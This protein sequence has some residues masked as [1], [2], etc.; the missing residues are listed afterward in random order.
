MSLLAMTVVACLVAAGCGDDGDADAESGGETAAAARLP[1]AKQPPEAFARELA[2]LV[3]GT[4]R[5]KQCKRLNAINARSIYRFPCPSPQPVRSELGFLKVLD[6]ASYGTGAVVDYKSDQAPRGASMVLFLGPDRQWGISHFGLLRATTAESSDEP[7]RSG[8]A[9][10][11]AGYLKAVRERDC[12]GYTRW[13]AIQ[14]EDVKAA[15]KQE[16]AGAQPLTL[17]LK[18]NPA[19]KPEYLGGTET[20]GFYRLEVTRP[21][22]AALNFSIFKT[23]KGSLR[24]YLVTPPTFAP[25]A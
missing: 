3:A 7:S 23:P 17:M 12:K 14:A 9:Q 1:E 16:I 2:D 5:P 10:A 20:Y 11:I 19:S 18:R 24:P 21:K 22:R 4:V 25:G 15:C 13:A 6:A 8:Y